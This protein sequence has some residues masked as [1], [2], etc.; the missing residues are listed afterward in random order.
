MALSILILYS[1][2]CPH[3]STFPCFQ[4][5]TNTF[6]NTHFPSLDPKS[7]SVSREK[8]F[9]TAKGNIFTVPA[10]HVLAKATSMERFLYRWSVRGQHSPYLLG[11]GR[12]QI[13]EE[14]GRSYRG[15]TSRAVTRDKRRCYLLPPA[16][17]LPVKQHEAEYLPGTPSR[18]IWMWKISAML[19]GPL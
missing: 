12:H 1:A 3:R 10:F 5:Y 11:E 16:L 4:C 6:M 19:Y 14:R 18:N 8:H 15:S 17:Q 2:I 13:P 7:S 9:R